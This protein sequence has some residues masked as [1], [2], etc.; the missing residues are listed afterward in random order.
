MLEEYKQQKK[1]NSFLKNGLIAD[2]MLL[3]ESD[4]VKNDNEIGL[5]ILK[6]EVIEKYNPD[7]ININLFWKT[8]VDLFKFIPIVKDSKIKSIKQLNEIS[9]TQLHKPLLKLVDDYIEIQSK[10]ILFLEIGPGYGCVKNYF[11]KK[12]G[13]NNYYAIDVNPLFKY[14]KLYKCDGKSIPAEVPN[15][16]IVYSINVFQHLSYSQTN[17]YYKEIYNRLL[18]GGIFIFSIF[19]YLE[20]DKERLENN[21][22]IFGVRDELGQIYSTFFNQ[23]IKINNVEFIVNELEEIGYTVKFYQ[24]RLNYYAFV[25]YKK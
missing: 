10:K 12:Y 1:N 6:K 18:K 9:L 11:T 25:C 4:I 5:T 15:V 17:S 22:K 7:N 19:S 14:K 21:K 2:S 13:L 20:K 23:Y 24:L 16:H 3:N 8:A